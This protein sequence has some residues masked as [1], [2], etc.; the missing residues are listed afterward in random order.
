MVSFGLNEKEG[1]VSHD[2]DCF[3]WGTWIYKYRPTLWD[4]SPI[5]CC[6]LN[7]VWG[8]IN[9][10]LSHLCI[11]HISFNLYLSLSSIKIWG[12]LHR[13]KV[14]L[15]VHSHE[16]KYL[17]GFIYGSLTIILVKKEDLTSSEETFDI[18][19]LNELPG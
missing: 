16:G 10:K 5:F 11:L 18:D 4:S 9:Y 6:Y 8:Q 12:F 19:W 14:V 2:A 3:G 15:N 13:I 1:S 7:D 17:C